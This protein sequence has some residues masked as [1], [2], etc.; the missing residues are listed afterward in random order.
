VEIGTGVNNELRIE[1]EVRAGGSPL[2]A[3]SDILR[4]RR[5]GN[6]A[7]SLSAIRPSDDTASGTDVV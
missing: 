6:T 2:Q 5:K 7:Q 1:T 3:P 4:I